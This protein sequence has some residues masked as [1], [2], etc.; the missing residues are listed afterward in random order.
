MWAI[1]CP[2]F[3]V[4]PSA[5]PKSCSRPATLVE[6]RTSVASTWPEA[7]RIDGSFELP[8]HAA[9]ATRTAVQRAVRVMEAP[10]DTDCNE[11]EVRVQMGGFYAGTTLPD[12]VQL[13]AV[14][15][16]DPVVLP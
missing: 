6:R 7:V 8:P 15:F 14:P 16:R 11:L 9:R 5:R 13:A 4:S 1:S 3:T 12:L 10:P 2:G